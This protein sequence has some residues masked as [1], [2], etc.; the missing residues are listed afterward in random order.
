MAN[1]NTHFN[2]QHGFLNAVFTEAD[3]PLP[4]Q[5]VLE[6]EEIRLNLQVPQQV[7]MN[8]QDELNNV[9]YMDDNEIGDILDQLPS[10]ES[11]HETEVETAKRLVNLKSRHKVSSDTCNDIFAEALNF[12]LNLFRTKRNFQ[13]H[14]DKSIKVA[15]STYLQRKLT[16][17]LPIET[18]SRL[19]P[20]TKKKLRPDIYY[21]SIIET[22]KRLFSLPGVL[23]LIK[24]DYAR[25]LLH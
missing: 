17:A 23:D 11:Y 25:K 8:A 15:K 2:K 20:I 1:F 9:E 10:V 24:A 7:Q 16:N 18:I 6:N 5:P 12:A 3:H 21:V 14:M 19:H 4:L 13:T 22:L